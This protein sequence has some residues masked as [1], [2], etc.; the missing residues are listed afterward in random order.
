MA[1]QRLYVLREKTRRLETE[2]L[3]L[4]SESVVRDSWISPDG[5]DIVLLIREPISARHVKQPEM[6]EKGQKFQNLGHR[7]VGVPSRKS[8]ADE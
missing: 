7:L 4:S 5:E 2:E 8:E 3:V 6:Y 1:A